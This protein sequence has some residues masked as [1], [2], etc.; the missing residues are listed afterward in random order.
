MDTTCYTAQLYTTASLPMTLGPK[1]QALSYL[2]PTKYLFLPDSQ[3]QSLDIPCSTDTNIPLNISH[4]PR[5]FAQQLFGEV[6]LD[7]HSAMEKFCCSRAQI[8]RDENP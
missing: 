2:L 1:V 4:S 3:A 5:Y 8:G 6:P 7:V